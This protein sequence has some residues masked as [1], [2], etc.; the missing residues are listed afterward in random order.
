MKKSLAFLALSI[1]IISCNDSNPSVS[2]ADSAI[3][4]A[5]DTLKA[6]ADTTIKKLDSSIH[7]AADT[8]TSKVNALADSAKKALKK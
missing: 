6:V 2:S 3:R 7:A 1:L 8:V 5:S 4:S